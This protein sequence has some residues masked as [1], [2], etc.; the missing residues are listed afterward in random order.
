M[1]NFVVIRNRVS[2]AIDLDL[3]I[4]PDFEVM[5]WYSL[6]RF[7]DERYPSQ[8]F[9]NDQQRKSFCL[10]RGLKLQPDE[11]G[12]EGI[13]VPKNGDDEKELKVGKRISASRLKQE[14]HGSEYDK[15]AVKANHAKNVA[16]SC[17]VQ[18]NSQDRG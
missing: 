10:K 8:K 18:V 12:V 14:D 15:E 4:Q 5:T 11:R 2:V 6:K 9:K 16:N 1:S 13:A 17:N 3:I 7:Y